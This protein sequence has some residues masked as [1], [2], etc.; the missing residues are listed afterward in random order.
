MGVPSVTVVCSGFMKQS[1]TIAENLGFPTLPL[2]E[3]HGH[4]DIDAR[5]VRQRKVREDVL[6]QVVQALTEPELIVARDVREIE[7]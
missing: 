6:P 4:S 1:R 7:L 2:A 3:Y 5:E